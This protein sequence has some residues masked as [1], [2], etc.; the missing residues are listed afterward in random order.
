VPR[1]AGRITL[2]PVEFAYFDPDAAAYRVLRSDSLILVVTGFS[3]SDEAQGLRP[4]DFDP[5]PPRLGFVRSRGFLFAQAIP[6]VLLL[7][8]WARSRGG[9]TRERP[10]RAP[11]GGAPDPGLKDLID[12]ARRGDPGVPD[13]LASV[14]RS[15]VGSARRAAGSAPAEADRTARIEALLLEVDQARFAPHIEP[16][17][18]M[19]LLERA[20]ALL[21]RPHPGH[22]K[23]AVAPV[24]LLTLGIGLPGG[25]PV[26]SEAFDRGIAA[27]A[28]RDV[29]AARIAFEDYVRLEPRD[30]SGWYD[31][32]NAAYR[33][34]DR[35][36][37]T[38]AWLRALACDPRHADA[39]HNLLTVAGS[40]TERLLTSRLALG[41]DAA[42]L[43]AAAAWWI[44][45]ILG[46]LS[47][48][49]RRVNLFALPG[50]WIG[51][52]LAFQLGRSAPELV[53]TR[54]EGTAI[55][56]EPALQSDAIRRFPAGEPMEIRDRAGDWI[57]VRS[58]I[59]EEG[60]LEV[61]AVRFVALTAPEAPPR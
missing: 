41:S 45:G 60:W 35:G 7:V 26:Q 49:L 3:G 28:R 53:T 19:R 4:P 1:E 52:G 11:A 16:E 43:A 37:A 34:G 55:H 44:A 22:G 40:A 17:S 23:G 33:E 48:R 38:H 21:E 29:G 39:R 50:V 51:I 25:S 56:G 5:S 18:V 10:P 15:A 9:R 31:L 57:R 46:F 30:A 2:G 27:L 47:R 54:T 36:T 6:L 42:L 32:G 59:G 24:L 13:R 8:G 20:R 14:L 58:A 12:A 61:N